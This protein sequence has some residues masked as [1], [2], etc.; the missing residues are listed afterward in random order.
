MNVLRSLL[1][2]V[3]SAD[4]DIGEASEANHE[5]SRVT[6]GG[7]IDERVRKIVRVKNISCGVPGS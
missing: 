5:L 6:L 7:D 3:G 4:R 2:A 1:C